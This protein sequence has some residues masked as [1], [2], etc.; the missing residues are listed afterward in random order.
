MSGGD[1]WRHAQSAWSFGAFSKEA[2]FYVN[3]PQMHRNPGSTALIS[4]GHDRQM[5]TLVFCLRDDR[6]VRIAGNEE[7]NLDEVKPGLL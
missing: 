6:G 3:G 1:T 2:E 4:S 5:V 7:L